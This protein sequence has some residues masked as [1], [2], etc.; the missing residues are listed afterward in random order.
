MIPFCDKF[1]ELIKPEIRKIYSEMV[2][3]RS[4]YLRNMSDLEN[5]AYTSN[6]IE[7]II[8]SQLSKALFKGLL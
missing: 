2:I 7:K 6:P 3:E 1:E 4:M 8:I 5:A